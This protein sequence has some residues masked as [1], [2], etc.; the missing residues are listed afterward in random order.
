MSAHRP[1]PNYLNKE[2]LF[3]VGLCFARGT[4]TFEGGLL[5]HCALDF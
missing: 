1:V 3:N 5:C 2:S 4:F